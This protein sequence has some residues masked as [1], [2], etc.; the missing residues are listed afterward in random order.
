MQDIF[1]FQPDNSPCLRWADPSKKFWKLIGLMFCH[2][3]H[4]HSSFNK[5]L[6]S[7]D[8]AASIASSKLI[9]SLASIAYLLTVK[10]NKAARLQDIK[11]QSMFRENMGNNV[12]CWICNQCDKDCCLCL[13][14]PW[15]TDSINWTKLALQHLFFNLLYQD[16]GFY[17]PDSQ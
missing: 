11:S 14:N 16:G 10:L 2:I 4:I 15:G 9:A 7:F 17:L 8:K 6:S 3:H 1:H 5:D 12:Q 13:H